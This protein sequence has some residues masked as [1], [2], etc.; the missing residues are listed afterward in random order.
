[1]AGHGIFDFVHAHLVAN[2][3][4]PVWWPAFCLAD[5]VSAAGVLAWLLKYPAFWAAGTE[6]D[7]KG[8]H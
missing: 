5:G 2:S 7:S 3:G 8:G 1:L 6:R 4:V